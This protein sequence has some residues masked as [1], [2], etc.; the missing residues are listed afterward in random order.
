MKKGVVL[1]V[2]LS[3]LLLTASFASAFSLGDWLRSIFGGAPQFSPSTCIDSDTSAVYPNGDNPFS[4]GT[5]ENATSGP[6]AD[7]CFNNNLSISEHYC[8][9]TAVL[10]KSYYCSD[11]GDFTCQDARCVSFQA[12][13]CTDTDTDAQH[14]NGDNPFLNGTARNSTGVIGVDQCVNSTV[15]LE[16]YCNTTAVNLKGYTCPSLGNY[17]CMNGK[18]VSNVPAGTCSCNSCGV[19]NTALG[20][21]TCKKVIVTNNLTVSPVPAGSTTPPVCI[22]GG[23]P[24]QYLNFDNKVFDCQGNTVFGQT[25]QAWYFISLTYAKNLTIQNCLVQKPYVGIQTYSCGN[26]SVINNKI[27]SS[28]SST[29]AGIQLGGNNSYVFN[30]TVINTTLRVTGTQSGEI[31]RH[32]VV[33]NYVCGSGSALFGDYNKDTFVGNTCD[34]SNQPNSAYCAYSCGGG[35]SATCTCNSCGSCQS[36]INSASCNVVEVSQNFNADPTITNQCININRYDKT[37]DCKGHLIS[38]S[39]GFATGIL[40]SSGNLKN[41]NITNFYTGVDVEGAGIIMENNNIYS[42]RYNGVYLSPLGSGSAA[43]LKNNIIENNSF[44][45]V[46]INTGGANFTSNRIINNRRSGIFANLPNGGGLFYN[47][48]VCGNGLTSSD[49]DIYA[50]SVSVYSGN[51]CDKSVPSVGVCSMNCTGVGITTT[52]C[53]DTDIDSQHINGDNPFLNGTARNSTGTIGVDQCVNSTLLL[54]DYCTGTAVNLKGYA[55]PSLGNYICMNGK[56][57]SPAVCSPNTIQNV[58]LVCNAQGSGYIQDNS[59]C[60]SGQ[61]CNATGSCIFLTNCVATTTN[62]SCVNGFKTVWTNYTGEGCPVNNVQQVPCGVVSGNDFTNVYW[63]RLNGSSVTEGIVRGTVW[64]V[65]ESNY[66]DDSNIIFEIYKN[67]FDF[68]TGL[69]D[70]GIRTLNNGNALHGVVFNGKVSVPWNILSSDLRGSATL[71]TFYFKAIANDGKMMTSSNL[72]VRNDSSLIPEPGP[73]GCESYNSLGR[74]ACQNPDDSVFD[75]Y[76]FG[77]NGV[78]C[79]SSVNSCTTVCSCVWINSSNSCAMQHNDCSGGGGTCITTSQ[80]VGVCVDG[81]ID[82][83]ITTTCDGVVTS[84]TIQPFPLCSAVISL[85]FFSLI[86]GI[87]VVV[88]IIVLYFVIVRTNLLNRLLRKKR[89][90]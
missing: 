16:G 88:I 38:G 5:A 27:I 65:A 17:I 36:A 63:A 44:N 6:L 4:N 74:Y 28:Y 62:S 20:N 76:L 89:R 67:N 26:C 68:G 50:S 72:G 86:N 3:V 60:A 42:N 57:V 10:G 29:G 32:K 45:G 25:T 61:T 71:Q 8:N 75:I 21:S 77:D 87:A 73:N 49:Y 18:C 41:C 56:C 90:K 35:V 66:P 84:S 23:S 69:A 51:K 9:G 79:G 12:N 22:S 31:T 54:E 34:T 53:T 83:N 78:P 37:L 13:S 70:E 48:F 30:N 58:C 1:V 14:I 47:N 39:G 40:L 24:G 64:M 85:P 7:F 80:I 81:L 46:Y 59:R 19:C 11:F 2:V 52:T 82:T 15:L 43:I 33:N 55:C